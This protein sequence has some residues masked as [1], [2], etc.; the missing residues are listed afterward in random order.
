MT[1]ALLFIFIVVHNTIRIQLAHTSLSKYQP[2]AKIYLFAAISLIVTGVLAVASDGEV[3]VRLSILVITIA[4]A[5][6]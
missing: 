4:T 5:V 2:F 3:N 6:F 1:Y